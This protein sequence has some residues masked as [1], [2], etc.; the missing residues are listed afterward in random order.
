MKVLIIHV[1]LV[2]IN[3]VT[4]TVYTVFMFG[5]EIRKRKKSIKNYDLKIFVS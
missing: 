2:K 3:I 1:K 4:R 5:I